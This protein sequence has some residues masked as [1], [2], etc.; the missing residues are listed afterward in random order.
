MAQRFPLTFSGND[1]SEVIFEIP[2][3]VGSNSLRDWWLP[4]VCNAPLMSPYGRYGSIYT[5]FDEL[6]WNIFNEI[7]DLQTHMQ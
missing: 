2:S 4:M 1:P 5:P 6:P 7:N 3:P